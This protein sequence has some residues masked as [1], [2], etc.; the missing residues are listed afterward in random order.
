MASTDDQRRAA[1]FQ[2][3]IVLV[4]HRAEAR[5]LAGGVQDQFRRR[6]RLILDRVALQVEDEDE[7]LRSLLAAVRREVLGES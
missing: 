2:L 7:E 5:R 1:E 4:T 3:R 6:A